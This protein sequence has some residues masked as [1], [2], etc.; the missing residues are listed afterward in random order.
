VVSVFATGPKGRR[1]W[2]FKGDKNPQHIYRRSHVI[3]FYGIL[4]SRDVPQGR[5]EK[6]LISF[7]HSPTLSRDVS[8]DRTARVLV[9]ARA[10]WYTSHHTMVH[11]AITRG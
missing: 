6:F 8:A 11:I 5:I 7:A 3:R 2:I 4:K 9:A 10:L 1:R